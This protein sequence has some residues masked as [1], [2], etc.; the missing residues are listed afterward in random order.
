MEAQESDVTFDKGHRDEME[1]PDLLIVEVLI[2]YKLNESLT[3]ISKTRLTKQYGNIF[4]TFLNGMALLFQ[5][6]CGLTY[7]VTA[8]L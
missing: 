2:S 3:K 5:R 4:S 1:A 6:Q 8:P 7:S